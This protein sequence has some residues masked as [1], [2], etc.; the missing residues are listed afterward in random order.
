MEQNHA[1]LRL[2]REGANRRASSPSLF[3]AFLNHCGKG[4]RLGWIGAKGDGLDTIQWIGRQVEGRGMPVD[5]LQEKEGKKKNKQEIGG[6]MN[7]EERNTGRRKRE[8]KGK[9]R[10]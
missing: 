10:E 6:K 7:G 5:G 1:V 9:K 4:G 2:S 3:L 8:K